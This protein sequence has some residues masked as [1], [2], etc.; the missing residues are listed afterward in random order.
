MKIV[1]S[2]VGKFHHFDLARQLERKGCLKAIF[3]GYPRRKLGGEKLPPE[4]I[5]TYPWFHAPYMIMGRFIYGA[6]LHRD[7]ARLGSVAFDRHVSRSALL[8][9]CDVFVGLSGTG[10]RSGRRVQE[11]GG[12]YICDRGSSHIRYQDT[13]LREEFQRWKVPFSGVDPRVIR[14]EESEYAA[15]D[16]VTVPSTFVRQSFTASGFPEEKLATVSYGV[17]LSR[18][19]PMG[20]PDP[21]TFELLFV[22]GVSLRKGIPYLLEAFARLKHPGKS[23]RIVGG[24]TPEIRGI[25]DRLPTEKVKFLGHHP[26]EELSRLMSRSHALVMPSIEEG[27]ALVMAQAMACGCPIVATH[28]TGAADLFTD[29]VEGSIVEPRSSDALWQALECLAADRTGLQ[30]MRHAALQRVQGID[31]WTQYG[32]RYFEVC[33]EL[34]GE[35][36]ERK[37]T[38]SCLQ[39]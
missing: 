13:I 36:S 31:G 2:C 33:Q 29:G 39:N 21:E 7:M 28:N 10:L 34:S 14:Q 17:N 30:D 16:V 15:A 8:E 19:Q 9:D 3:T 38:T 4:K 6:P 37:C 27:L 1:Q 32:D 23:L 35:R 18:F 11:L 20:E 5:H 25:L 26:Q 24:M 12:K 22:G